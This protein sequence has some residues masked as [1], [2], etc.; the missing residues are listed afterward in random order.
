MANLKAE[1]H[2]PLTRFCFIV[3]SSNGMRPHESCDIARFCPS[4]KTRST[5]RYSQVKSGQLALIL[6][7]S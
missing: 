3:L 4:A 5:L 7:I 1:F 2:E 6:S